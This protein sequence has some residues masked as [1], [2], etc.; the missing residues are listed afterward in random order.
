MGLGRLLQKALSSGADNRERKTLG[1]GSRQHVRG[2]FPVVALEL[3]EATWESILA[4]ENPH[5]DNSVYPV[6]FD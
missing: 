4:M 6:A 5:A 1:R 3:R 2:P